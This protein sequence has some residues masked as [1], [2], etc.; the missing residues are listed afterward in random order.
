MWTKPLSS[1]GLVFQSIYE[2]FEVSKC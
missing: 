2:L 1:Y